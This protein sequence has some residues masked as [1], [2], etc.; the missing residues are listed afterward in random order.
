MH[1]FQKYLPDHWNSWIRNYSL[2][3]SEGK[4]E[5]LN[6]YDFNGSLRLQ[7][8]DGSI[9]QFNGAFFVRDEEREEVA[10][11]GYHIFNIHGIEEIRDENGNTVEQGRRM[12]KNT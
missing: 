7:F 11:C 3:K 4:Y 5:T 6:A 9:A 1:P 12:T 2:E 8:V 10:D